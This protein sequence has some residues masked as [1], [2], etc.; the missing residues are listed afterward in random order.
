MKHTA[1]LLI[2]LIATVLASANPIPWLPALCSAIT[3]SSIR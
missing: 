2:I 3:N 1:L